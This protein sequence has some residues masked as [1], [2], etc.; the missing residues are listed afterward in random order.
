MGL[1]VHTG[2]EYE[3]FRTCG[4]GETPDTGLDGDRREKVLCSQL[5]FHFFWRSELLWWHVFSVS[6][7]FLTS[8]SAVP[9][10][11]SLN[12]VDMIND[13]VNE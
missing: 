1:V 9:V 7:L 3:Y 2:R 10:S 4:T 12:P 5:A 13:T 11:I 6:S 8:T